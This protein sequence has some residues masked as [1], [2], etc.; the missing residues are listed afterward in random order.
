VKIRL[1]LA[2]KMTGLSCRQI[3]R[4]AKKATKTL[5]SLG[6]EVWSPVIE[7]GVPNSNRKLD[8]LS[9]EDLLTK[10]MIDKKEGMQGCHVIL[11]LDGDL[12]SEGVSIERGYMRWYAWRPTIRVKAP[13]HV[14]SI[15]DIEDDFIAANVKQA[16][17]FIRRRWG[18]RKKWI[19]WKLNHI[20]F[21]IPKMLWH[22]IKS[23][24]L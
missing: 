21:G 20:I 11:D 19:V 13:G 15:S 14:Y 4:K 5:E 7:E 6:I 17:I 16:G 24:W 2:Q 23:L 22:Q 1:Y 10:W 12:H 3:R 8:V 9:K 18:T